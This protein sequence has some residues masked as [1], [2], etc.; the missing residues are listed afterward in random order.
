MVP[1]SLVKRNSGK[2]LE[3]TLLGTL[4]ISARNSGLAG[5]VLSGQG[6]FTSL[7][8]L[9]PSLEPLKAL[10]RSVTSGLHY[11]NEATLIIFVPLHPS[12]YN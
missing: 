3:E 8:E 1:A 9:D 2:E 11:A 5:S 6:S 7:H 4:G 12:I 10:S